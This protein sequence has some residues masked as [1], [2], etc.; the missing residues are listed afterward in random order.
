MTE[1]KQSISLHEVHAVR[2]LGNFTGLMLTVPAG[3]ALALPVVIQYFSPNRTLSTA[4]TAIVATLSALGIAIRFGYI[5]CYD[6]QGSGESQAR[7]IMG[8]KTT[9]AE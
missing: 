7:Y 4:I 9:K 6:D 1:S 2:L 5:A 8:D 3:I